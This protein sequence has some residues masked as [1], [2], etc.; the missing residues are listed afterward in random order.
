MFQKLMSELGKL[1]WEKA[2]LENIL[3]PRT[4][5]DLSRLPIPLQ[6]LY[7]IANGQEEDSPSLFFQYKFSSFETLLSDKE[8][9]DDLAKEE[10]WE[11]DWWDPNWYPFGG[12]ITGDYL[13]L[14]KKTGNILEFIHDDEDRSIVANSLENYLKDLITG[15][16]SGKF[17]FN[18]KLGVFDAE[19]ER[20]S[21]EN[22]A[23]KKKIS[24][25]EFW[26]GILL[27]DFPKGFGILGWL[28][29]MIYLAILGAFL[30]TIVNIFKKYFL[31]S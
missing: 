8:M 10:N 31:A 6:K 18:P 20:S 29:Q 15:L 2:G 1:T 7:S 27:M 13:V 28:I 16:E 14:D 9:L 21:K 26:L 30:V 19:A 11:K 17:N 4:K 12:E 23:F 3:N 25:K 24:S 22:S 5:A